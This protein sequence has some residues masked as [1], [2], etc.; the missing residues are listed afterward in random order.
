MRSLRFGGEQRELLNP[1]ISRNNLLDDTFNVFGLTVDAIEESY[2]IVLM[3]FKQNAS[4]VKSLTY[5]LI[6]HSGDS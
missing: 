1:A 3:L 5:Y 4:Y 2:N 6:A